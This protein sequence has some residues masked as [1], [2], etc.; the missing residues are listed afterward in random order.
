MKHKAHY[1]SSVLSDIAGNPL[2]EALRPVPMDDDETFL[3]LAKL[4]DFDQGEVALPAA[5]RSLLPRRLYHFMYPLREHINTFNEIY[6]LVIDGY[7]ERNPLTSKG[8]A[9]LHGEDQSGSREGSSNDEESHTS[10]MAQTSTIS[11]CTGIS[12]I[13]KTT[14]MNAIAESFGPPV[15]E[16]VKYNDNPLHETQI[17]CLKANVP[18]QS[19]PKSLCVTFS[20]LVGEL[21]GTN[22]T[23]ELFSQKANTTQ[24]EI[25]FRKLLRRYNVG[26]VIMDAF[27]NISLA[28]SGGKKE[29]SALISNSRDGLGVPLLLTGTYSALE[30][31][32]EN[33]S[34]SRRFC[35]GGY[36]E[37]HKPSG[38]DEEDWNEFSQVLWDYQ[39]VQKPCKLTDEIRY[40]M[41]E[42]SQGITGVLLTIFVKAQET[43][44]RSGKETVDAAQLKAV[45]TNSLKP[46][47]PMIEA[48][49]ENTYE[50]LTR[51]EDLYNKIPLPTDGDKDLSRYQKLRN[52]IAEEKE[53]RQIKETE[54]NGEIR[55]RSSKKK[56]S[57]LSL[58]ELEK[59]VREPCQDV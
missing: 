31:F 11:F 16:H 57:N 32:A 41:Y 39:W 20:D 45:Y 4:P 55:P 3:R 59:K 13:G 10:S 23:S 15:I 53:R 52:K 1:S 56:R 17:P 40:A 43:A 12:G 21:I 33:M 44:I 29:L 2:I 5:L 28:R 22:Q 30:V 50:S 34:T 51:Y 38:P 36:F 19:S 47:H 14:L 7:R 58:D 49:K 26:L 35:E 46:L 9:F 24:Y 37:L 18:D 25:A 27:E 6:T 48:L 54:L 8:Q 42:Y